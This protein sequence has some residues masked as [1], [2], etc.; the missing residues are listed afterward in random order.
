M[1]LILR[2]EVLDEIRSGWVRV[3]G[4][5]DVRIYCDISEFLSTTPQELTA[6]TDVL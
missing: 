6:L 3:E 1:I 5:A 2:V 4:G